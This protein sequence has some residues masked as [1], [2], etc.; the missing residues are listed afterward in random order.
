M[1]WK[2]ASIKLM[3][4]EGGASVNGASRASDFQQT[5]QGLQTPTSNLQTTNTGLQAPTG[6]VLGTN[7][8]IIVPGTSGS[9][10]VPPTSSG[11]LI[12]GQ[13]P[14]AARHTPWGAWLGVLIV[15][16]LLAFMVKGILKPHS[17][18]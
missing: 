17:Y 13:P 8:N 3:N 12:E 11:Q 7:T 5:A 9:V 2:R 15:I 6:N 14:V 16:A 10:T 4:N 18:K 1:L